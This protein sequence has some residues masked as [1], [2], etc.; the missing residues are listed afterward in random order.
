MTCQ[1]R[2]NPS[3]SCPSS[4]TPAHR[5]SLNSSCALFGT[6]FSVI[7]GRTIKNEYLALSTLLS[8]VGLGVW[9]SSGKKQAPAPAKTTETLIDSVKSTFKSESV[10]VLRAFW[11]HTY[12]SFLSM[13][14]FPH[15]DEEA[16]CAHFFCISIVRRIH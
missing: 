3:T 1:I 14:V 12:S 16:L 6:S 7:A 10:Y 8:T 4:F 9:A 2:T 5:K 13:I 11:D 15:S